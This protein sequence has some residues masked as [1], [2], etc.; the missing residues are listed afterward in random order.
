MNATT[1]TRWDQAI[2]TIIEQHANQTGTVSMADIR[3]ALDQRGT[4]RDRQDAEL[5]R[6]SREGKVT[7][8]PESNR[9]MLTTRDV[10]AAVR[11]GGEPCHLVSWVA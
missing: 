9:K 5:K 4:S 8:V 3:T 1:L 6:M 2:K 7:L 11:V 10:S